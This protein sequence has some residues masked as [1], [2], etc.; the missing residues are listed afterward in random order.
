MFAY[1]ERHPGVLQIAFLDP[2]M[3]A[4]GDEDAWRLYDRFGRIF[5][6]G[7][8]EA[9]RAGVIHDDYDLD[10]VSHALGGLVRHG[11]IFGGRRRLD[12]ERVAEQL[13][14]FIARA[15]LRAPDGHAE[16]EGGG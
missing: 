11:T 14:R 2:V 15:L 12:P 7:L 10:L 3:I 9:L 16:R 8:R 5:S 13:T 4:P 6:E 1:A